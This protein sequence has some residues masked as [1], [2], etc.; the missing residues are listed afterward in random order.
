M[1]T[2]YYGGPILTMENREDKPEAVLVQ[3]GVIKKV[4]HLDELRNIA[5]KRVKEYDLRGKCLMPAFIDAHSHITMAGQ[6]S[7]LADLTECMNYNDIV[8]K[9]KSYIKDH[10]VTAKQAVLGFGYD[11]NTLCEEKHPTRQI[12]DMVS[13]DIPIMILHISGHMACVNSKVLQ[14][15]GITRDMDDPEGG[16]IGRE[17]GGRE[18]NGYLE[19]A[20]MALVQSRIGKLVKIS[21]RKMIRGM[22]EVYIQNGITT[23]QD[24]AST[25]QN[26]ALLKSMAA[27]HL[28][29]T[30]VVAYPLMTANGCEV[31]HKNRKYVGAYHNRLKIGGYKLVLDGSPQGRSAWMT[32]PYEGEPKGYCAYPWLKDEQVNEYVKKAVDEGHQILAHCNGDAA[33]DQFITAYEKAVAN[34]QTGRD[35]RPVMIHCQTARTDQLDRMKELGMIPSIFVGHVFYWGDVH[36]KNFGQKRGMRI[37]PVKDALSRG[38]NLTFHQDTPVTKPNMMHSVWCAVKRISKNGTI[39]GEDQK[40]DVYDALKCITINAAYQYFEEEKKGS[41]REGK[42]ADLVVLEKNPLEVDQMKIRE[43]RVIETIKEGKTIYKAQ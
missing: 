19:E 29:K 18:P 15:C 11:H 23:I 42:M 31:L 17:D 30:D 33:G 37:S 16:V 39:V 7:V 41:I 25:S 1:K 40:I 32:E 13:Q 43:I 36:I 22:Q 26:I 38:L 34:D 9:L 3:N 6:V 28:L 20:A 21:I 10:H 2:L 12:L 5:G 14:M 8:Q 24:G 27:M 4:G 35:M